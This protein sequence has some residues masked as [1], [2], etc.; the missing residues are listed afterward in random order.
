[1]PR[2]HENTKWV[3]IAQICLISDQTFA[4]LD[5]VICQLIKQIKNENVCAQRFEG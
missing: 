3:K 5:A 2:Y 4:N 1:M